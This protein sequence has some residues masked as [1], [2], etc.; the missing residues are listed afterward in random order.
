MLSF[1][2]EKQT[3]DN[4]FVHKLDDFS[5]ILNGVNSYLIIGK[6]SSGK[7]FLIKD[8][9]NSYIE[10]NMVDDIFLF[11]NQNTQYNNIVTNTENIYQITNDQQLD[12]YLEKLMSI[13]NDTKKILVVF[14]DVLCEP[15][16]KNFKYFI[17]NCRHSKISFI[18]SIPYPIKFP[19]EIR[20]NFDY[21]LCFK[22]NIISNTKRLYEQYFGVL[23]KYKHFHEIMAQLDEYIC[24][25]VNQTDTNN[26]LFTYKSK[27]NTFDTKF[28]VSKMI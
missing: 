8:I 28:T 26:K 7:I 10:N 21:V 15:K 9:I 5:H 3:L 4:Q 20:C 2:C 1:D 6:K 24:I 23:P 18:L 25:I 27:F 14:D 13:H 16:L 22:D 11:T 12:K 19:P 17:Q